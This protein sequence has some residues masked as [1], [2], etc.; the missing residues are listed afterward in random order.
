[1]PRFVS[2]LVWS[3]PTTDPPVPD[4]RDREVLVVPKRSEGA[5]ETSF[6]DFVALHP[7][8]F[9]LWAEL[10]AVSDLTDDDV[11]RVRHCANKGLDIWPD[12]E[13][14]DRFCAAL[15]EEA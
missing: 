4:E 8:H 11:R 15:G 2:L 9:R 13:A 7:E 14:Y 10:P 3:D 1:M 12:I 5:S 6:A